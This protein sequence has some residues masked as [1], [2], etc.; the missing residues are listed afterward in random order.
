M[1]PEPLD[2]D[3]GRGEY[4]DWLCD[5]RDVLTYQRNVLI[6]ECVNRQEA[7]LAEWKERKT[8]HPAVRA[9]VRFVHPDPCEGD[10]EFAKILIEGIAR[11]DKR[12]LEE[13][14]A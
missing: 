5:E 6:E 4:L 11:R 2:Q 12:P 3:T 9:L 13:K 10:D 7:I 14:A 1:N 8:V